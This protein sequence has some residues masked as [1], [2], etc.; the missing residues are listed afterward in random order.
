[1]D[2]AVVQVRSAAMVNTAVLKD[3]VVVVCV[4]I[5]RHNSVVITY[6]NQSMISVAK[7][8]RMTALRVNKLHP[9]QLPAAM[10]S[11]YPII[12]QVTY[13]VRMEVVVVR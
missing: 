3:S 2:S 4:M 13:V 5:L 10:V 6:Q 11:R 9:A 12:Q 8:L 7:R 1:M